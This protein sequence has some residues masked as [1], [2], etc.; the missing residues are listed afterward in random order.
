[1][2][3]AEEWKEEI[4]KRFPLIDSAGISATAELIT[5]L[6]EMGGFEKGADLHYGI[7]THDVAV[8]LGSNCV[9]YPVYGDNV[10][11]RCIITPK[12]SSSIAKDIKP[13]STAI[14]DFLSIHWS[15][16]IFS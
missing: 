9:I 2:S 6:E 10:Q 12:A 3:R 7:L 13:T 4:I 11:L 14:Q 15:E 5:V 1:M 16:I 8:Y